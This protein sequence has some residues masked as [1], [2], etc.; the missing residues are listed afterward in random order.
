MPIA[1]AKHEEFATA[2]PFPHIVLDQ[3][4][5][6]ELL[7]QVLAEFPEPSD[8]RWFRFDH[9]KSHKLGMNED[10]LFGP[11]T[12]QLLNQLNTA[13]FVQFLET[14]TG[15]QGLIP[16]PHFEGG[17]LHQIEPGGFLK[18]HVDFNF[19]AAWQLDRRVNVLIYLNRDWDDAWG[20][21]LELWDVGMTQHRLV[22][23]AFNRMVIFETS[24]NSKH[25][26]PDPL[27]CP[28]GTSRRSLALYYYS[29]GRPESEQ[30]DAHLTTH[31]E[32]PGEVFSES[33]SSKARAKALAREFAPPIL[34]RSASKL[35]SQYRSRRAQHSG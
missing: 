35:R 31:F 25:G 27:R 12:R 23:P 10:W 1:E 26:H 20:G 9:A 15:I 7:S 17:G 16:D 24:D 5:P 29:N 19:H 13:V 18:V 8:E 22:S 30:S 33:S 32:R 28:E 2:T 3:F 6:D 34:L 14:L 4:L 21:Q 11:S